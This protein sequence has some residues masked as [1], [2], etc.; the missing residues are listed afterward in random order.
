MAVVHPAHLV[1]W[2]DR[3]RENL[4]ALR[5]AYP[6]MS[7]QERLSAVRS[8][9]QVL[10]KIKDVCAGRAFFSGVLHKRRN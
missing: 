5:E 2:V 1:A 9:Y 3:C 8:Q 4:D 6:T 7:T 10:S